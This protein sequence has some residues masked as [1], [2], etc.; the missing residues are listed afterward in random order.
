MHKLIKYFSFKK[1]KI[2]FLSTLDTFFSVSILSLLIFLNHYENFFYNSEN[3]FITFFYLFGFILIN[4]FTKTYN[5]SHS[6]LNFILIQKLLI[7]IFIFSLILFSF[8]IY[9]YNS[10]TFSFIFF[11]I[12]AN[13]T[14]SLISKFLISFMLSKY[15]NLNRKNKIAIYGL[16]DISNIFFEQFADLFE[17]QAFITNELPKFKFYKGSIPILNIDEFLRSNLINEVKT[18]YICLDDLKDIDK[19]N[20]VNKFKY[21]PV[22]LKFISDNIKINKNRLNLSHFVNININYLRLNE[23]IS[24]NTNNIFSKL[25]NKKILITGA[26]GSIG[27]EIAIQIINQYDFSEIFLLDHSEE[28]MFNLKNKISKNRKKISF[29]LTSL[30]DYEFISNTLSQINPDIIIHAAAYKH[31]ELLEKNNT[32]FIQNNILSS[33]N[34]YKKFSESFD[35]LFLFISSDKAV[36]PKSLMGWSKRICEILLLALNK[37]NNFNNLSIVRFGNV[38]GSSGSF[39]PIFINQIKN[40]GPITI[41]N[42]KASRYLMSIREAVMLVLE[43]LTFQSKGSV[44]LFNMKNPIKIYDI[45]INL[46]NLYGLKEKNEF[47]DGDIEIIET[48]LKE[49]EKL[50]EEIV[51]NIN[52]LKSENDHIFESIENQTFTNLDIQKEIEKLNILKHQHPKKLIDYGVNIEKKIQI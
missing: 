36:N 19:S 22:T 43:T 50:H 30:N 28:N 44:Y 45:I 1:R 42:F 17:Y 41:T 25:K 26:G 31:V 47:Q 32:N 29:I 6:F 12:Y 3:I 35:G 4:F 11:I 37:K 40:G 14:F 5:Q 21:K 2:I 46:L 20:I 38:I 23:E 16:G 18:I 34:L 9:I 33:L 39:I 24:I 13:F 49:G 48:G 27:S 8:K 15:R 52:I 10:V 7:N 51:S